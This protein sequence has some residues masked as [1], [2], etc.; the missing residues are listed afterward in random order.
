MSGCVVAG[1]GCRRRSTIKALH[2]FVD[3]PIEPFHLG[4]QFRLRP[5]P[6]GDPQHP[7]DRRP[8][9]AIANDRR[10]ISGDDRVR[11]NVGE[12]DRVRRH[13]RPVPDVRPGHDRRAPAEPH[14][15][16]DRRVAR[17]LIAAIRLRS[18]QEEIIERPSRSDVRPMIA[19]RANEDVVA[20]R[21]EAAD[22]HLL[23]RRPSLELE[24]VG[25]VREAADLDV[26][27]HNRLGCHHASRAPKKAAGQEGPGILANRS[28]CAS[29]N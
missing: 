1:A 14:V 13:D 22:D 12:H 27:A 20:D 7:F 4:P 3:R 2:E 11:G 19:P 6:P 10:G 9:E 25:K 23:A 29:S 24:I 8:A 5:I 18:A 28:F 21:A 16:A 26:V 17:S 15:V